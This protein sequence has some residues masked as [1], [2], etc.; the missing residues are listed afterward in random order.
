MTSRAPT[1]TAQVHA[2]TRLSDHLVRLELGGEGLA[3]FASTGIPDEWVPLVVPGQFQSRYYT[4]RSWDG[5]RMVLDVVVHDHGLVTEWTTGDV[6]GQQVGIGP[7]KG[8]FAP[9][10]GAAWLLL[11]GDLTALPAIARVLEERRDLPTRVWLETPPGHE[12][13]LPATDAEVTWSLPPGPGESALADV[14]GAI[15]WPD[16][17]GYFWMAGESSQMRAIRKHLMRERRLPSAAYDVMGYW[18]RPGAGRARAVDPGPVWAAGKA[19]G[20]TDEQIWAAYDAAREK[21][22]ER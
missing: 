19:A 12:G 17:D 1:Y 2:R 15:D 7:A 9:P 6:V 5:T 14:V 16:G 20:H 21:E 4:V 22:E 10:S 13:L 18:R 8:S 11:V 3:G